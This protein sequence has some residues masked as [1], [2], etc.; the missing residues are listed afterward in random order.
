[1]VVCIG[2]ASGSLVGGLIFH[3]YSGGTAFRVFGVGCLI[4]CAIH[5][6]YVFYSIKF[7]LLRILIETTRLHRI[8]CILN[9]KSNYGFPSGNQ[10]ALT[11]SV[12]TSVLVV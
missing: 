4:F 3:K 12:F 11:L 6:T 9:K 8:M 2:V 10:T 7:E 5:A 1:M